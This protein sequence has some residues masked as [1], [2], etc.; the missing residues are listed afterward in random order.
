M[1]NSA[2]SLFDPDARA[3]TNTPRQ[4]SIPLPERQAWGC[5]LFVP[6]PVFICLLILKNL[7]SICMFVRRSRSDGFISCDEN[8]RAGMSM[9]AARFVCNKQTS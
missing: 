7:S 6:L 9:L 8:S 3:H 1:V 2:V 4:Q 5:L